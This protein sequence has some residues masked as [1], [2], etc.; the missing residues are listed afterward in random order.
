MTGLTARVG[1]GIGVR[2]LGNGLETVVA[3][4]VGVLVARLVSPAEYGLFGV[5]LTV[6]L[7]AEQ[8]GSFGMLQALVQRHPLTPAH[9]S[10]E[11]L[12]SAATAVA[13]S[14]ALVAAA[15]AVER[16]M[17]LAGLAPVLRWQ[18]AVLVA[19]GL[20]LLPESRLQRSLAFGRLT[21]IQLAEKGIG[22]A[23][24]V[25]LAVWGAGARY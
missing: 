3:L 1:H 16:F 12:V 14:L 13:L 5:A 6:S 11:V 4:G 10:A 21:L 25:A 24:T 15:P 17:G 23:L 2:V 20:A 18:S 9:E 8:L 19:R 22:G 7:L